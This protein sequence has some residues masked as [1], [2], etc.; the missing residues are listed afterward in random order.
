MSELPK[1]LI[2]KEEDYLTYALFP[3]VAMDFLKWR[4]EQRE[5]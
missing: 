2:E 1:D 4:K 3:Q 5:K